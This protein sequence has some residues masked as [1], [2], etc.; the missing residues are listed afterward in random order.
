VVSSVPSKVGKGV[1]ARALCT[2]RRQVRGVR[3]L[4]AVAE[5]A[6]FRVLAA[7]KTLDLLFDFVPKGAAAG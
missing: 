1:L 3:D 7:G 4:R 6:G 5:G 2:T